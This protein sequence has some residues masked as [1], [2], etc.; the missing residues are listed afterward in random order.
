MCSVR[1]ISHAVF[2]CRIAGF[3][4]RGLSYGKSKGG[5]SRVDICDSVLPSILFTLPPP[6]LTTNERCSPRYLNVTC[7]RQSSRWK[8]G[9]LRWMLY[10]KL[11]F[12][13]FCVLVRG[14]VWLRSVQKFAQSEPSVWAAFPG[15]RHPEG[16]GH[17]A[18]RRFLLGTG[19]ARI[20]HSLCSH[21]QC[22]LKLDS[23]FSTMKNQSAQWAV[24]LKI[25]ISF[26]SSKRAAR[27]KVRNFGKLCVICSD[28]LESGRI[29]KPNRI[30]QP[31]VVFSLMPSLL[32]FDQFFFC[33]NKRTDFLPKTRIF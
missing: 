21:Q 4:W 24:E 16:A 10:A 30:G 3:R 13:F 1:R 11:L 29:L 33:V 22:K 20:T 25:T 18:E 32:V 12:S 19:E 27:S 6:N 14:V 28:N 8:S 31:R 7:D 26:P 23:S 5:R 17:L 9:V 2:F 15:R